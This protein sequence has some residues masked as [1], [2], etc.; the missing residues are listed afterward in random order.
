M[1]EPVYKTQ[2]IIIKKADLGEAGRLLTIYTKN[3]GKIL[4]RAK[5]IG[6]KESK[7][8]SL[9][10]PFNLCEF[11]IARSK[12][13]DV[14]TNV[15]PI[16]E[17]LWLHHNLDSLA[18]AFYFAELVDKL[19]IAPE[20]DENLWRLILR[21]F[22]V[23]NHPTPALPLARGGSGRGEFSLLKVKFLFEQKLLEFL[24]HG[25]PKNKKA[26]EV[27]QGLAGEEIKSQKFLSNLFL[28]RS[29]F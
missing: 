20:H 24:G 7:L 12:T 23:L 15:Y 29:V 16:K 3:Y 9:I 28:S 2:G 14:L 18:L 19:V 21:A 4:V 27:I 25:I 17:F 26:L 13:I 22:E 11:L 1:E 5:G 8:K 10:E 6:K